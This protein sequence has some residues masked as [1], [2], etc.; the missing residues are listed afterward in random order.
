MGSLFI[1]KISKCLCELPS[2]DTHLAAPENAELSEHRSSCKDLLCLTSLAL[3]LWGGAII[4]TRLLGMFI[5][6]SHWGKSARFPHFNEGEQTCFGVL[7]VMFRAQ[8]HP[9]G[10]LPKGS[11]DLGMPQGM[12]EQQVGAEVCLLLF[13]QVWQPSDTWGGYCFVACSL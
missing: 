8:E 1:Y 7:S 12:G 11:G 4:S 9:C 10:E 5:L 6:A 3:G 2:P 13:L